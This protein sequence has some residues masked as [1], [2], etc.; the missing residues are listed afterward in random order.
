[1]KSIHFDPR[2]PDFSHQSSEK[3]FQCIDPSLHLCH[4]TDARVI[5]D[6]GLTRVVSSS[7]MF[8]TEACL[9]TVYL[10]TKSSM[11][12]HEEEIGLCLSSMLP[13]KI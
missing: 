2:S 5:P 1:M 12:N 11:S 6:S 10:S 8:L 9:A 13:W 4:T 7:L 3:P